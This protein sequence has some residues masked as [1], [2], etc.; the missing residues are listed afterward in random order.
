MVQDDDEAKD[1]NTD[2]SKHVDDAFEAEYEDED[3]DGALT[4]TPSED[5]WE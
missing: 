2:V 3:E 1:A 4:K 5:E